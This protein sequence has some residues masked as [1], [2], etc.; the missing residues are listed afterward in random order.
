MISWFCCRW[1][2]WVTFV[3][4]LWDSYNFSTTILYKREII[5]HTYRGCAH[6]SCV[7]CVYRIYLQ[8]IDI[9]KF[10]TTVIFITWICTLLVTLH[11]ACYKIY[12]WKN[13]SIKYIDITR[14]SLSLS[15]ECVNVCAV[16]TIV[17]WFYVTND[18]MPVPHFNRTRWLSLPWLGY[19]HGML[20]TV[21]LA[22]P[23]ARTR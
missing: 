23:I 11:Q 12:Y 5:H 13:V 6:R 2:F 18:R 15:D 1:W 16:M 20:S 21:I 14:V 9:F 4:W 10:A 3:S 8:N 19:M 22:V 17:D 7:W